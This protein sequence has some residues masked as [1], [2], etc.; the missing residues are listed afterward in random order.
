MMVQG[1][2]SIRLIQAYTTSG[3]PG[4]SSTSM[5][6]VLSETKRVFSQL[7]PPSVVL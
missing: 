5:A 3:F 2:R 7:F 4:W 6:P 1:F